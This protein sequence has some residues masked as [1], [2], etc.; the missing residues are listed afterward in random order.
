MRKM[1]LELAVAFAFVVTFNPAGFACECGGPSPA[2]A[3]ISVAPVVFVGTPIYSNDDGSGTFI[4]Q[5]LYKF[6]VDE[7]FKGLTEGT[8]AVWIDP[9]SY[10]SCYADYEI[11]TR[12]LVFASEGKLV[13]V[14]TAAMTVAKPTAKQKPLPPGFDPKMP[15]YYAPECTGTRDA[16]SASDDITWLRLWKKGNV[17][18]RIQGLVLDG[19]D[20]PLPGVKVT[21]NGRS[22]NLAAT[23]DAAGAFSIEP[24]LPGKYDLN[25]TLAGY[26]LPWKPEVEVLERSCGYTRLSMGAEGTLSGTVI[27]KSGR[28]VAGVDLELARMLG[29]EETFPSIQYETTTA[30]G[31]FRYADLPGGDYLIGV[32][33]RSQPDVD[34]PYARTYAPGVSDR[35]RAQVFHLAPGQKLSRLRLQLPPRLR[36]RKIHVAVQWPDGRSAGQEVSVETDHE[37]GGLID[38]ENAKKDGTTEVR[39]FVATGCTVKAWMWLTKLGE[40][41]EPHRAMSLPMQI[42]AG[43]APVSITLTLTETKSGLD[44]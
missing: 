11:G 36:L 8:K 6:T 30:N 37:K 5:T 43:D 9:G 3:Y 34:T 31:F 13:P 4:Q 17:R 18:T 27:D 14:D 15:V 29:R 19:L 7:I 39:C 21:A 1:Q 26:D 24:V 16:A 38:F 35:A 42:E 20:W 40:N 22:G 33:L 10:T 32:N 23:T 41:P 2:C 28:P 12:L 25:A 44:Q